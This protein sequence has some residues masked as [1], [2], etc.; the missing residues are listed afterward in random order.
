MQ[1][2]ELLTYYSVTDIFNK[3]DVFVPLVPNRFTQLDFCGFHSFV[4][5]Y[6]ITT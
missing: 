6:A 2:H 3:Y 4:F 5:N 1:N